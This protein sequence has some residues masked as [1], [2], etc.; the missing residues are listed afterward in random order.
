MLKKAIA[1]FHAASHIEHV[2]SVTYAVGEVT[3][4]EFIVYSCA[5]GIMVVGFLAIVYELWGEG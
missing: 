1:R 3:H 4:L 5:C 2:A